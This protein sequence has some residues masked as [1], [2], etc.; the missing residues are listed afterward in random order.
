MGLVM[1]KEK[2]IFKLGTLFLAFIAVPLVLYFL[3][4]FY[5]RSILMETIS[6]VTIVGFSILISQ[7]FTSRLNKKLVKKIRMVNVLA[8]HK[9]IG[10]LFLSILLLHPFFVVLPKVFDNGITYSDAIARLI[11]TFN[12]TGVILGLIAYASLLI[13]LV[14]S[15]FRLKLHLKYR[16]WRNLHGYLT[17][18]FIITAAWHV[19]DIGRHSNL[20][21]SAYYIIAIT[22]GVFYLLKTYLFKTSKR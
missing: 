9:F 20:A 22:I 8:V 13:L 19:I 16:T 15:F 12:S 2:Y 14:T 7:F 11:T 5:K 3:G 6:I 1:K 18:L 17:L 21:F 10:Y 4:D